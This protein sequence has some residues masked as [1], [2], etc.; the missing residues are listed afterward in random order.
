MFDVETI[1]AFAKTFTLS[2]AHSRRARGFD[3]QAGIIRAMVAIREL[4]KNMGRSAPEIPI[5]DICIA[6]KVSP[7]CVIRALELYGRTGG[8]VIRET[9]A[10]KEKNELAQIDRERRRIAARYERMDHEARMA[11]DR[12][13]ADDRARRETRPVLERQAMAEIARAEAEKETAKANGRIETVRAVESV[14]EKMGGTI[15]KAQKAFG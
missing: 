14:I 3:A 13:L 10:Q 5:E 2:R 7:L 4:S 8:E 15:E 9:A 11:H 6:G 1:E 12:S